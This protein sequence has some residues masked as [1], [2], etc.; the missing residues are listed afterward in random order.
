M[1]GKKGIHTLIDIVA[2]GGNLLLNIAPGP[3]G[4]WQQ[5]AYD[6]LEEYGDWMDVNKS[7]IYNT[8]PIAPFKERN[9]CMTQNKQGNVHLF[10]MAKEGEDTIPSE[11]IVNSITPKKGSKIKMLGSNRKLKWEKL[12]SGFKVIIPESLRNNLPCKYAWVLKIDAVE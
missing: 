7:A 4:E 2:K 3:D 11:I 12:E 9:I 6:L 1:S 8:K 5:G 10:Y